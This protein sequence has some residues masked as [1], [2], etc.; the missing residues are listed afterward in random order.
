MR[1]KDREMY[2]HLLGALPIH[3][4]TP[5][6]RLRSQTTRLIAFLYRLSVLRTAF[7]SIASKSPRLYRLCGEYPSYGAS[8]Y[9]GI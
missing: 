9:Y 6:C 1:R 7:I 4:S 5:F 2:R 8:V 3:A